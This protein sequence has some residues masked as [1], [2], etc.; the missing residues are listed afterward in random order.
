MNAKIVKICDRVLVI[1]SEFDKEWATKIQ[2]EK[3]RWYNSRW[4]EMIEGGAETPDIDAND[5]P[6]F[7][8]GV[9]LNFLNNSEGA[10]DLLIRYHMMASML[11]EKQGNYVFCGYLGGN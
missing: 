3:F 6:A 1:I 2:Q 7:E 5:D 10:D 4:L 8:Y 11:L 9:C